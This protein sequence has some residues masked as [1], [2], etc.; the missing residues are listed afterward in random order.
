MRCLTRFSRWTGHVSTPRRQILSGFCT[1][2][3]L[4]ALGL[5]AAGCTA[6][7]GPPAERQMI[8]ERAVPASASTTAPASAPVSTTIVRQYDVVS[9][10]PPAPIVE[11]VPAR[12]YPWAV[13]VPGYW[14]AHPHRWIWVGGRWR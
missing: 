1:A 5:M 10:P 12:P 6:Y 7:V 8:I 13:W 2:S 11:V 4:W 3:A 9:A 14:V